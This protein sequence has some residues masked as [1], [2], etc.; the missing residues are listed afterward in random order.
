MVVDIVNK[1][2][3]VSLHCIFP[4][5]FV[6][7]NKINNELVAGD[8]ALQMHC[9]PQQGHYLY[10]NASITC[11]H[12]LSCTPTL[13]VDTHVK[14][15]FNR[16]RIVEVVRFTSLTHIMRINKLPTNLPTG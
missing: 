15:Y 2:N 9:H 6:R 11:I 3:Y 8:G 16:K 4:Q 1:S 13:H 10:S 14:F 5:L 7:Y 12:I